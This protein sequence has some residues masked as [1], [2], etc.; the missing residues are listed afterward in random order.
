MKHLKG[1]S[2]ALAIIGIATV[3]TF[4]EQKVVKQE[5]KF[6]ITLTEQELTT[7]LSG[8]SELPMKTSGNVYQVIVSQ[9]QAQLQPSS[10]PLPKNDSTKKKQ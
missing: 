7:V 10:K 2:I 6:T 5:R 1:L 4:A 9:A 8:L 3:L